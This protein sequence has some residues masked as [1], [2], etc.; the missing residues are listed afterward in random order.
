MSL[1]LLVAADLGASYFADASSLRVVE[2]V[3]E[4]DT[5]RVARNATRRLE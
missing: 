4:R 3:R 1:A 2:C 5:D